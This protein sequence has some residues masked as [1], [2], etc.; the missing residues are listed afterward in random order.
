M[1]RR[2]AILLLRT[3]LLAISVLLVAAASPASSPRPHSLSPDG[4]PIFGVS[5]P[6]GNGPSGRAVAGVALALSRWSN[7]YRAG[8]P[9]WVIAE[10]RNLSPGYIGVLN[11]DP[12]RFA[13]ELTDLHTGVT[14]ERTALG[15]MTAFSGAFFGYGIPQGQSHFASIRIDRLFGNIAPGPYALRAAMA[16]DVQPVPISPNSQT[17][18]LLKSN[19]LT[20]YIF[21]AWTPA[22]ARYG[23][24]PLV[25]EDAP[26]D[27]PAGAS[28]RGFALSLKTNWSKLAP[29]VPFEVTVELRSISGRVQNVKFG[30]LRSDY[31]FVVLNQKTGAYVP[32]VPNA[33]LPSD[34]SGSPSNGEPVYPDTSV[35]GRFDLSGLYHISESGT[36]SVRVIGRPTI[37]GQRVLLESN[38]IEVTYEAPPPRVPLPSGSRVLDYAIQTDRRDY[39]VGQPVFVRLIVTNLTDTPIAY[40]LSSPQPPCILVIT[41]D[42]NGQVPSTQSGYGK[43]IGRGVMGMPRLLPGVTPFPWKDIDTWGYH[44]DRPGLYVIAARP[45]ISGLIFTPGATHPVGSSNAGDSAP[46]TIRILSREAARMEPAVSLNAPG[47]EPAF[48]AALID[49]RRLRSSLDGAVAQMRRGVPY[50]QPVSKSGNWQADRRQLERSV[51]DLPISTVQNSSYVLV[52]ANLIAALVGLGDAGTCA[53]EWRNADDA[54]AGLR[55]ADYYFGAVE[56]ELSSGEARINDTAYPPELLPRNYCTHWYTGW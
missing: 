38:P 1:S 24:P 36:Y 6:S 29:R 42:P 46:L 25:Y 18:A 21:P 34:T 30:S 11:V 31:D 50:P 3:I 54:V 40:S 41:N 13:V 43:S 27:S 39:T 20:I 12:R 55:V 5:D 2:P 51:S 44:L 35:Y 15:E 23:G 7:F 48:R 56:R 26:G 16:A 8:T 49:Y 19:A 45:N 52:R 17:H 14:V 9:A 47:V 33:V 32:R 22:K 53:V 10:V 28:A 4:E 37:D